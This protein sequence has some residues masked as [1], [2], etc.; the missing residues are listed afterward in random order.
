MLIGGGTTSGLRAISLFYVLGWRHFALFGFD[1]CLTG[2]M[3]RI[4]GSGLKEGE[5]LDRGQGLTKTER[6][7]TATRLWRCKP[8]TSKPI[9]TTYQTPTITG[10]GMG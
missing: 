1:S 9:T 2:D 6:L 4:N 8:S 7:S 3:L 5:P 10:L